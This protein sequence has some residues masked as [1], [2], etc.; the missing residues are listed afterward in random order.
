RA[1]AECQGAGVRVMMITGD[2][3]STATAIARASGIATDP[4]V[5]TGAEVDSWDDGT[6]QKRIGTVDAVARATPLTKLRIVQALQ[7]R[8]EVV[9]MTGDGVNDAPALRAAHIGVAMGRRGSDVAREAASLVLLDDNFSAL[10]AAVRQG[11]RIFANL[12]Q[13]M[14]YVLGVHVP[15]IGL[16]VLPL[17][18]GIGPI[19]LP[20]HVMLLEF[21][22]DPA[23]SLA[24]EAEPENDD[25]MKRPP[26]PTHEHVIEGR[27]LAIAFAQGFTA[28]LSACAVLAYAIAHQWPEN[29]IR[30]ATMTSVVLGNIVLILH[31][32]NDALSFLKRLKR[33]NRAL[34]IVVVAALFAW[35]LVLFVPALRSLFRLD[36]SNVATLSVPIASTLIMAFVIEGLRAAARHLQLFRRL[37]PLDPSSLKGRP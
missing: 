25:A 3:P 6:L 2:F 12:R 26:R 13:A 24:F 33:P 32:R 10:V 4:V 17:F 9:A 22:I 19:L 27:H 15:M 30:A 29:E 14:V 8:G 36:V 5:H 1:V 35:S 11:R 28:L 20:L 18:L 16:S 31:N 21:V 7:A 34:W 23:C 37:K